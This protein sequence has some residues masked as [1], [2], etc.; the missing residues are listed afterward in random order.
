MAAFIQAPQNDGGTLWEAN[1]FAKSEE[2]KKVTS[3]TRLSESYISSTPV[4]SHSESWECVSWSW[5]WMLYRLFEAAVSA[6]FWR[7]LYSWWVNSEKLF[8]TGFWASG[9]QNHCICS[10]LMTYKLCTHRRL[11]SFA[12]SGWY[13]LAVFDREV[14][15]YYHIG[16]VRR[17]H[18]C[19]PLCKG[20][21][22]FQRY[23]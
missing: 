1:S 20:V 4:S 22:Q 10:D 11:R 16:G 7:P 6:G 3:S 23:L 17:P 12:N 14:T 15:Y 5:F 21:Y 13:G 9:N 18:D 8:A 2:R 19:E